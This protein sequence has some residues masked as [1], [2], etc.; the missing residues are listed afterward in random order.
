M[1]NEAPYNSQASSGDAAT[2][3]SRKATNGTGTFNN[4]IVK[5]S[6][7]SQLPEEHHES[8]VQPRRGLHLSN[9]ST[10]AI[11]PAVIEASGLIAEQAN[12]DVVCPN[13]TQNIVVVSTPEPDHATR[14]ARINSFKIVETEYGVIAY[15]MARHTTCKGV[16]R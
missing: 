5:A 3:G 1:V 13:F 14:Y 12:E 15:K 10:M 8:I 6:R 4:R 2:G 7:T 11:Q 16:T 9:V